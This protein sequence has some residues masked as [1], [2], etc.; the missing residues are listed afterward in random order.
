MSYKVSYKDNGNLI[1][2]VIKGNEL[3][4]FLMGLC[5]SV[6]KLGRSVSGLTIA[7]ANA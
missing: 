3:T 7:G 6:N 5:C 4:A 1:Q 2:G